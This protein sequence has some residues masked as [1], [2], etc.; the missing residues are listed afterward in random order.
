MTKQ[1]IFR[2]V[3]STPENT[4]PAILGQMLDKLIE[5]AID[6]NTTEEELQL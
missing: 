5:E 2:Y 6:E 3:L 1:D 4:N